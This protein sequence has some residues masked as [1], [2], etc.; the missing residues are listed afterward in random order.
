MTGFAATQV[1]NKPPSTQAD[2]GPEKIKTS[3]QTTS[4]AGK[5]SDRDIMNDP[6]YKAAVSKVGGEKGARKIGV[7]KTVDPVGKF[8][9]G[10]TI[11]SKVKG[12]LEK[13]RSQQQTST[14]VVGGQ[15]IAAIPGGASKMAA[16]PTPAANMS[17]GSGDYRVAAKPAANM[18]GGSGDY[19]VAAKPAAQSQSM[20]QN[21]AIGSME[22]RSGQQGMNATQRRDS[23]YNSGVRG[24]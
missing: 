17:G 23:N 12:Q 19:R 24:R 14:S 11:W 2:T 4:T 13:E 5:V 6:R 7:G 8:S 15:G 18:S 22:P 10:E 9:K 20:S 3:T 1:G 16:K 21:A